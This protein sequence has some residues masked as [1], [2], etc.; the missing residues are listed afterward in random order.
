MPGRRTFL[1]LIQRVLEQPTKKIEHKHGRIGL[2]SKP[3]RHFRDRQWQ[4]VSSKNRSVSCGSL[5]FR[6]RGSAPN[7]AEV[8][9]S[10]L[11][12][13][14]LHAVCIAITTRILV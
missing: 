8:N 12:M 10:D 3:L 1:R 6:Q 2:R 11:L 14:A 7:L 5:E 9:H 13:P 4:T